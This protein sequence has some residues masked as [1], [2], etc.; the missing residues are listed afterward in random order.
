MEVKIKQGNEMLDA[1]IEMVDGVMVVSP[2]E[3]K[4]E[5]KEGDVLSSFFNG[6]YQGTFVFE[7][8]SECGEAIFHFAL[9]SDGKFTKGNGCNYF[10]Y[11]YDARPA[12]EDEKKKLFNKLAE[13]GYE[14]KADTKE[15]VKLKW[16]PKDGETYFSAIFSNIDFLFSTC[17]HIYTGHFTDEMTIKKMRAFKT[18]DECQL[19]C[20]KLNQT[21]EEYEPDTNRT[22]PLRDD[23]PIC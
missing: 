10:G 18:K 16:K 4:F 12:T 19:F 13:E 14:W 5:P 11:I 17:S 21:I 2:K 22:T 23:A 1:T 15:L 9:D 7:E 20:D 6:K 3:V 8:A